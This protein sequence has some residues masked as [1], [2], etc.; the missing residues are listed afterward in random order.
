MI[1]VKN[2]TI[3]ALL[4]NS[5]QLYADKTALSYVDG[6]SYTYSELKLEIERV[7]NIL[8]GLGVQKGDRVAILSRNMPNWGISFMAI[9][10]MGATVVPMLPDFHENEIQNIIEHSGSNIIFVS[11]LMFPK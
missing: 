2:Q 8:I 9:T 7:R 1:K 11:K 5:F 4:E 6:K 3:S 10:T